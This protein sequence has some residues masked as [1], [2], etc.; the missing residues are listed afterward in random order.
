[1]MS[2]PAR[3][4]CSR[5]TTGRAAIASAAIRSG[6]TAPVRRLARRQRRRH[7]GR[8]RRRYPARRSPAPGRRG[9]AGRDQPRRQ[10]SD[11]RPKTRLPHVPRR[12]QE[13]HHPLRPAVQAVLDA[14]D[15]VLERHKKA[16]NSATVRNALAL[17]SSADL[18]TWTTHTIV[19]YHPDVKKHAFKIVDWLFDGDD[20]LVA[21][22]GGIRRRPRRGAQRPRRE[23][24]HVPP[25]QAVPYPDHEGRGRTE[26]TMKE[27]CCRGFRV[28]CR[29]RDW[30]VPGGDR[31]CGP[32][33]CEKWQTGGWRTLVRRTLSSA[34]DAL[35][36]YATRFAIWQT[37][38]CMTEGRPTGAP[39][40]LATPERE[41]IVLVPCGRRQPPATM[42]E[43]LDGCLLRRPAILASA[44]VPHAVG[45]PHATMP[46]R[47][48]PGLAAPVLPSP[49]LAAAPAPP[50]L[51]VLV[52]FDQM[53]G[54]S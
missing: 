31:R 5:P 34:T 1:M 43:R 23:L 42:A 40:F 16:K 22:R 19:L 14:V 7:A 27:P 33:P 4:T 28:V 24:S 53:R 54:D 35:W 51:A 45:C 44:G 25:R 29:R 13:I 52:V 32:G 30:I 36:E 9:G 18:K 50:R 15:P 10:D 3:P 6:S 47:H 26:R 46:L 2:A 41:P 48:P 21:W 37:G 20:L 12:Q 11:V 49:G 38:Q 8:R 39:D 17:A